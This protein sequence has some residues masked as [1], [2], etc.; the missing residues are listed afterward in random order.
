MVNDSFFQF[1]IFF[2]N[3]FWFYSMMGG[4]LSIFEFPNKFLIFWHPWHPWV[5]IR[6]VCWKSVWKWNLEQIEAIPPSVASYS[7]IHLHNYSDFKPLY[8]A[9][10][11]RRRAFCKK[12]KKGFGGSWI[13]IINLMTPLP[14]CLMIILI[15][16]KPN[17][18]TKARSF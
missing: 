12:S 6:S 7:S 16:F 4:W 17:S 3:G 5:C 10:I 9:C 8:Q 1:L 11:F 2:N 15:L 18:C 13:K 14:T